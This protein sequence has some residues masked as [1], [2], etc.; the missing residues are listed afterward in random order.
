MQRPS[1]L[2]RALLSVLGFGLFTE[3]AVASVI[4]WPGAQPGE[5]A[6]TL[7]RLY[8]P[9][10]EVTL[11]AASLRV[12]PCYT[13]P[14]RARLRYWATRVQIRLGGALGGRARQNNKE[15]P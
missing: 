7:R 5:A 9:D 13:V 3:E 10:P 12:L 1:P 4:R 14:A 2:V 8:G 11:L 6:R 15:F